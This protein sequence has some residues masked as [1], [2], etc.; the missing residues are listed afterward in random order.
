MKKRGRG[1]PRAKIPIEPLNVRIS[2]TINR[3][4]RE[5]AR[6]RGEKLAPTV[7]RLLLLGLAADGRRALKVQLAAEETAYQRATL[8]K[9]EDW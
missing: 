8:D 2:R 5:H 3:A 6:K 9:A 7:A 4:V 1:R